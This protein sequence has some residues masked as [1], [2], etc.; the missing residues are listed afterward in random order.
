ME[1]INSWADTQRT[2][3]VGLSEAKGPL[4]V[5]RGLKLITPGAEIGPVERNLCS[6]DSGALPGPIH[7]RRS[8]HGQVLQTCLCQDQKHLH[9]LAHM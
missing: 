9:T 3:K 6:L 1:C 4:R 8:Q 5:S 7:Q 2:W